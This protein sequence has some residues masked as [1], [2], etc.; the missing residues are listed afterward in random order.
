[1]SEL[2]R[3]LAAAQVSNTWPPS[4]SPSIDLYVPSA[5]PAAPLDDGALPM[6]AYV[7]DA[8]QNYLGELIV[9]I[10]DGRLSAI[11]YAWV[12]DHMP[13]SLPAAELVRVG[14]R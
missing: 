3:Q 4:G 2:R 11:E 7:Y 8:D 14:R 13:N 12:T 6:N 10:S 9:W 1:M 5:V